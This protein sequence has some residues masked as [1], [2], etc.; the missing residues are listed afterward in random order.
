MSTLNVNTINAA[1]SGQAVAVDISN[2]RSFRNLIIN[3]A[4]NVAQRGTSSTTNGG[5]VCDRFK[6]YFGGT[7]EACTTTQHALTSSD[8]GPWEKG[9]R[10]SL[11][12]TNGNQTGGAG[13]GDEVDIYYMVEAQDLANSGWDNTSAS[14]YITLSWWVRSSVAQNFH[15]YLVSQDGTN[16]GLPFETGSLTADTWTKITK[17][18]PGN[19]NLQFD[20]DNG[21]GLGINFGPWFGTNRTTAS[22]TLD[23]WAAYADSSRT[24]DTTTTWYTTNDA[25]FEITGVQLEVG[26]YATD[27]EHRT[28][29][30]ELARSKRYFQ[31]YPEIGSDSYSAYPGNAAACMSSTGAGWAVKLDTMRAAPTVTEDGSH[32]IVIQNTGHSVTSFSTPHM[33]ASTAWIVLTCSGGGMGEGKA[34]IVGRNNDTSGYWNFS[35]EL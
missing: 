10:N 32:R 12:I 25:T 2:P 6:V 8:T 17:K 23:A 18:I 14:S 13:A 1:T 11:H 27:F 16:Q 31:R 28:Y 4:M 21:P 9:F 19:S 3:G 15:G 33:S 29:G 35:A 5:I 20:N 30:D 22:P 24:K 7:D 26:S 34:G